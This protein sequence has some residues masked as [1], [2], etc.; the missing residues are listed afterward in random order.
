MTTDNTAN[1]KNDET[2]LQLPQNP[3]EK[4][5]L[6]KNNRVKLS[7]FIAGPFQY[8]HEVFG[9][10]FFKVYVS[11][12][13]KSETED[14]LPVFVSERLIDIE[15][16]YTGKLVTINGQYRSFN[17]HDGDRSHL[18]LSIFAREF[19]IIDEPGVVY[20]IFSCSENEIFLDGFV[21][22]TPVYRV[23][24]LGREI[25]DILLAVN[26]P[27]GKSDYIPCICWG[28]AAKFASTLEVG[29]QVEILGRIQSRNYKK[30]YSESQI[31]DKIAYEVSVKTIVT[32]P[33][34]T[35]LLVQD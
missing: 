2:V 34:S 4:T 18:V 19:K 14:V 17:L 7:G 15:Q 25:T 9:E 30:R 33:A 27:Y 31:E 20:D 10:R 22:K 16:D 13:R 35:E 26:R 23:T 24:P 32:N 6:C 28:R 3:T 8:E 29:K 1:T 5:L 11:S 21:C 12:V